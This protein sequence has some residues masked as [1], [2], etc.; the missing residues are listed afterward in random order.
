MAL[1]RKKARKIIFRILIAVL[2]FFL[3]V[4]YLRYLELKKT[5]IEK[6][7]DRA[8]SILG[9]RV[10][11]GDLSFSFLSG[12]DLYNMTIEN[13]KGFD[14]FDG[15]KPRFLNRGKKRRSVSTLSIPRALVLSAVEG[16]DRG[17]EWVDSGQLLRI[18]RLHLGI[19][20]R[21]LIRGEFSF[22]NIIIH[23]PE[24]T[25]IKNK[26]GQ[27]NI[28][29]ALLRFLSEKSTT[30]Y[31]VDEFRIVS[32][33]VDFN[34]DVRFRSG[35][36][37]L[38]LK[39]IS[40]NPGIKTD[41]EGSVFYAGNRIEING[42]TTLNDRPNKV[43]VSISSKD[44]NLF[45]LGRSLK[46]YQID[47][48]KT[49]IDM[50]CHAEGDTE[51][52][53]HITSNIQIKRAGFSFLGKDPKD[54][55]LRTD[56]MFNLQDY[57]LVINHASLYTD[58][59]CSATFK[60][61]IK[62]L[63][64]NPSYLAE[65]K[66][67]KLDLSK[68]NF[69]KDF[70]M[71]GIVTA[72][73]INMSGNLE[74][75]MPKVSGTLQLK[76][77]EIESAD[78]IMREIDADAIFSSDK[79]I[80]LKGEVSAKVVRIG[81]Y[82]LGRP[83]DTRLSAT[84]R[85]NGRQIVFKSSLG[86]S[87]FELKFKGNE[88]IYL[89]RGHMMM[90]GTIQDQ[91]FSGKSSIEIKGIQYGRY[92]IHELKNSFSIEYKEGEATA[93]NF[94]VETGNIQSSAAQ[95]KITRS[96]KKSEYGIEIRELDMTLPEQKTEVRK[97]NVEVGLS[98]EKGIISGGLRFS[99]GKMMIQEIRL[100]HI[101][102]GGRFDEKSFSLD[103]PRVEFSGGRISLVAEG[104]TSEGPF[105][106]KMNAAAEGMNLGSLSTSV[107]RSLKFPY[108]VAGDVRKITFDGT[109][110][111]LDSLHG[112]AFIE[113]RK[114]SVS[115]PE[116]KR[117]LLKDGLLNSEIEFKGKDLAVNIHAASGD[118]STQLTGTVKDFL[119]KKR[120]VQFKAILP[121]VKIMDIRDSFWDIFPDN[122]LYVGLDGSISSD[123]SIDYSQN[124]LDVSGHFLMKDCI[125][126]GENNEYSI[127][128]ING[129]IPIGYSQGRD[130][131]K[132]V[133]L[134]SYEK[135]QFDHLNQYYSQEKME[136]GNHSLTISSL[137]Y[138]FPLME[139]IRLWVKQEG[140]VLNV[141][142]FSANLF[143]G[144]IH[145]S[146]MIDFSK[147]LNCRG[148]LLVKGLSMKRLCEG[149]DPIRGFISG[150]VDGIASFK[151]TGMGIPSLMGMADFW[152]YRTKDEKTIISKE[153]LHK[154]GGP[155]LKAYLGNRPFNKGMMSLYLTNG[156]LI[157]K[158]LEISNRNFLNITDLS[159]KVA[160]LNNRISLEHLLWTITEAADRAK[161][162][163]DAQH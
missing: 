163:N 84:L 20:F 32:G 129:I 23:F 48:E 134:P 94:M 119:D 141:T 65:I 55:Q 146:A 17:V 37:H 71:K 143:G 50:E 38:L 132:T 105:P 64:Q 126:K 59:V 19:R 123:A 99:V 161:K 67:N 153:F 108:H 110:H 3:L 47:T 125:V 1:D 144:R 77:G 11:I 97:C 53:I 120:R 127:G 6:I 78:G 142:R 158:E 124:G 151:G 75:K 52:G 92:S 9:Q 149:M 101:S 121:E 83:V 43:N 118:I 160:P 61:V 54:I 27:L 57:F 42:W 7:S 106:I 46:T 5:F 49:R 115:K 152:T 62:N 90:D 24:L 91:D 100:D 109:I 95:I 29:D 130:E 31:Q 102:G 128:P 154:L 68:I 87:P 98:G 88:A 16:S 51:K 136:E 162:K 33:L 131:Q 81:E 2:I 140:N 30:P 28:S 25:L 15:A 150:K 86:F 117:S 4:T 44:F 103:I 56:A 73:K 10:Q 66:I 107:L 116:T 145:G 58:K 82:L 147:E 34:K 18:K 76:D 96:M 8:T 139:N 72:D 14:T 93:K 26:E 22:K 159:V 60:G 80:S 157:F 36:I 39:N 79:E 13:P 35:H 148:G 122:L 138:G 89:N 135:S 69:I 156:D 85:G 74:T 111:S 41:I 12:V 21:Q 114:I 113:A 133:S 63:K 155:S 137:T 112:R 70:K 40:S 45:Q 104:R